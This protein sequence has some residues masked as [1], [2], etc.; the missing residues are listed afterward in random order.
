MKELTEQPTM[1][2]HPEIEAYLPVHCT[3]LE[4]AGRETPIEGKTQIISPGGALL[5]IQKALSL[6]T[7]LLFCLGNGLDVQ[8]RVVRTGQAFPTDLGVARSHGIAFDQELDASVLD[9]VLKG[10]RGQHHPRL[11]ARIPV[12]YVHRETSGTG[13]CLNLSQSGMFIGTTHP[14]CAGQDLILHVRSTENRN[15]FTIPGRVVWTNPLEGTNFFHVGMGVQFLT[16]GPT[17]QMHLCAL[18][19]KLWHRR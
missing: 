14:I 9:H 10:W 8:S 3:V 13:T 2:R 12:E 11:P 1:R 6:E 17:E 7:R 15:S 19:D 16:L 4:A 18:L 5:L